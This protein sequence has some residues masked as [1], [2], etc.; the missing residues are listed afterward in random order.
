MDQADQAG[1][2]PAALSSRGGLILGDLIVGADGKPVHTT[3]D[4][5]RILDKHEVGDTLPLMIR[6]GDRRLDVNITLVA[7]P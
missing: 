3:N 4:L 5:Y 6:R 2:R 1:L 7:V